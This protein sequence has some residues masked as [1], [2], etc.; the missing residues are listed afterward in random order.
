VRRRVFDTV[1]TRVVVLFPE[2]SAARAAKL[3]PVLATITIAAGLLSGCSLIAGPKAAIEAAQ[4]KT[5]ACKTIDAELVKVGAQ[6]ANIGAMMTSDLLGAVTKLSS[7]SHELSA[8]AA[9]LKN[10]GVKKA[11][12]KAATAL[13][14]L[15]DGLKGLE[16]IPTAEEQAKAQAELRAKIPA[17]QDAFAA[18]D[19]SCKP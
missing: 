5:A 16:K 13:A 9:E 8:T 14:D 17:M 4:S 15:V 2:V 12:T 10:P 3:L 19:T 11:A 18:I 1:R 7:L 6:F